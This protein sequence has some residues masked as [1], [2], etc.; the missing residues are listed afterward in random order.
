MNVEF[1]G[2]I[3]EFKAIK[4]V[5]ND[6]EMRLVIITGDPE[7]NKLIDFDPDRLYKVIISED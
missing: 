4:S 3:K 5:T 6:K 2:E 1:T 7:V